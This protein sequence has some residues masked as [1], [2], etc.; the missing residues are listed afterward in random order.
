[1]MRHFFAFDLRM[2][3]RS[4]LTWA[5]VFLFCLQALTATNT[6]GLGGTIGNANFNAPLVIAN[7]V[8]IF[9]LMS[10]FFIALFVAQPLLR[11]QELGIAELFFSK[12]MRKSDYLLGRFAAGFSVCLGLFAAMLGLMAL[13]VHMPWVEA[14]L[15][16]TDQV[17]SYLWTFFVIVVPNLLFLAGGIALL[18]GLT[19]SILQVY[20][21]ILSFFALWGAAQAMGSQVENQLLVAL[22]DPFG[23][24]ALDAATRYW[25]LA[26]FNTRSLDLSGVLLANRLMWGG[27]GLVMLVIMVVRFKTLRAG[28]S[29][30]WFK[31][32]LP[33]S[34]TSARP[35]VKPTTFASFVPTFR[36]RTAV[37]QFLHASWFETRGV[38][39]TSAYLMFLAIGAA[40]YWANLLG[41]NQVFGSDLYP[42][43]SWALMIAARGMGLFLIITIVFYAGELIEKERAAK[44]HEVTDACPTP[45]V[46]P[47]LSKFVALTLA[48]L[49]NVASLALVGVLFQLLHGYNKLE[50]ELYVAGLSMEVLPYV[51]M[52][53]LAIAVQAVVRNKYV[54]YL[55]M[56]LLI[57][58]RFSAGK[59]GISDNLIIFGGAPS[60]E[61]SDLNGYGNH[62]TPYLTFQAYWL[63]F[64]LLLLTLAAAAWVRGTPVA[65]RRRLQIAGEAVRQSLAAPVALT[66]LACVGLGGWIFYNTHLQ[67]TFR[68]DAEAL[69]LRAEYERL[70]RATETL[71]QPKITAVDVA[72]DMSPKADMLD[73]KVRYTVTNPHQQPISELHVLVNPRLTLLSTN[74]GT[75]AKRD[76]R[77]GLSMVK[78]SQPLAPG[79][80]ATWEFG[81]SQVAQGFTNSGS[82]SLLLKN[83]TFL[84]SS[85][86]LPSFGYNRDGQILDPKERV[87]HGLPP[88]PAM[89]KIDSTAAHNIPLNAGNG[90]DASDDADW[91]DFNTVVS[92]DPDQVALA[93]GVLVK[94]WQADGRRYFH[95]R[96]T[97]KTSVYA[98]WLSGRWNVKRDQW[99]DVAIEVYADPKHTYNVD[100][101]IEATKSSLDYFSTAFSP[102]QHKQLRIVEFPRTVGYFAEALPGIVPYAEHLGFI[103][104][105]RDKS[106]FDMVYYVTAHEVAHQWWGHQ[107]VS[108]NVQGGY[109]IIESLAQ[110]SSLMVMKKT[111]GKEKMR[112][113]LQRELDDYLRGRGRDFLPEQPLALSENQPYIHYN[114]GSLA[115]YRLA[116]EMGEEALNRAL[117]KFL[118]AHAFQGPPYPTSK[119][120]L[121]FIRAEAGPEHE[122][123]IADLFERIT[124]HENRV[125]QATAVKL[126]DGRYEVS[127]EI[128]AKKSYADPKGAEVP[129]PVNDWMEIGVFARPAGA[130]ERN[131]K[132]LALER[133]RID[134]E[135]TS[136]TFT[137]N[138][139]PYEVGIDPYNKLIDRVSADNRMKV[140]SLD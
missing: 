84:H 30:A 15:V 57:V 59:L 5:T 39:R 81:L 55:V 103:A 20:V 87:K 46:L 21:G 101:M 3:L 31:K 53:V 65:L 105:V 45:N 2:L 33:Q 119:Q 68:S 83:G 116:E 25:V 112:Q 17:S 102:Y 34:T 26:D 52:S 98:A 63:A 37:L 47:L 123:L 115:F 93:P 80:S 10:M 66:A 132:V 133:R 104:D 77:F 1:M 140:S 8:S 95:Y 72:M 49:V 9:T 35:K 40:L 129:T 78:L 43:T 42:V 131:E 51:Q 54:G 22:L 16:G 114:K 120:L 79:E 18:A 111:Y 6:V 11:D 89:A 125:T 36:P 122:Q 76:E 113:F 62:L 137:V 85:R 23:G 135:T 4:P 64:S 110:Y 70:Y 121:T 138:E 32:R 73:F 13:G 28:T 90:V 14:K 88:L 124:L 109:M 134:R 58:L 12:P 82:Q 50:P 7:K 48:S 19:R 126:P 27:L 99:R 96:L 107:L 106:K 100:R 38:V 29:R 61:F 41:A 75:T 74:F 86:A 127:I 97:G 92:T 56:V 94:E 117:Q 130:S 128:S 118:A 67:H 44:M 108:A 136:L 91:V 60:I 69:N 24:R 139:H 71:P